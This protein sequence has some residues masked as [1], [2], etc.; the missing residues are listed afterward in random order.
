M[1]VVNTEHTILSVDI[2]ANAPLQTSIPLFICWKTNPQSTFKKFHHLSS[3]ESNIIAPYVFV[4]D[5]AF[6]LTDYLIKPYNAVSS[7]LQK[8]LLTLITT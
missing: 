4:G 8:R 3:F 6:Q 7:T 2:G 1:A 5:E